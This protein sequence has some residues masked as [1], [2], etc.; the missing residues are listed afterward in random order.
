M[1]RFQIYAI[2]LLLLTGFAAFV[3]Y[4]GLALSAILL[5]VTLN[6]IMNLRSFKVIKKYIVESQRVLGEN[7]KKLMNRIRNVEDKIK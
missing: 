4:Y 2:L 3:Y 6:Y 7:D 1:K 5:V